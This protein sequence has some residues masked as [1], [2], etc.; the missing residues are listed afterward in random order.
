MSTTISFRAENNIRS[1][2]EAFATKRHLTK[3]KIIN[4]AL[5]EYLQK[6]DSK[7]TNQINILRMIDKDD[8]YL[9]EDL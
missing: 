6:T 8:D 9:S 3:T 1:L 7:I 2:L 4:E 5:A